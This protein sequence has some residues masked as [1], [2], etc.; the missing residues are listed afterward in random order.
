MHY[1]IYCYIVCI[2]II[3]SQNVSFE[4]YYFSYCIIISLLIFIKYI[5]LIIVLHILFY[6]RFK[7][8]KKHLYGNEILFAYHIASFRNSIAEIL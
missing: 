6:G 3:F 1:I 2:I 4:T 7:A 5:I 8:T